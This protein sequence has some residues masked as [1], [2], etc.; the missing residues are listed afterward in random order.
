MYYIVTEEVE[1]GKGEW[2]GRVSE[3]GR[4]GLG[5]PGGPCRHLGLDGREWEG[6]LSADIMS[7]F[8]TSFRL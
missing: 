6:T 1:G 7:R 5:R 2:G 4:E 3:V 8:G